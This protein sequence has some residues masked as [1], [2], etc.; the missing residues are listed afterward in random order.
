MIFRFRLNPNYQIIVKQTL[1]LR[2]RTFSQPQ[3]NQQ[4]A[5]EQFALHSSQKYRARLN[6]ITLLVFNALGPQLSSLIYKPP[7]S[8]K[9]RQS[10]CRE[11][12]QI[13]KY[14]CAIAYRETIPV[15]QRR[16]IL[17]DRGRRDPLAAVA[18]GVIRSSKLQCWI[19]VR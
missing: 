18:G 12:R 5:N 16:C 13:W 15:R 8:T 1:S 17:I 9:K 11:C 4:P 10:R 2:S 6:T 7:E 3:Y 19:T 14:C